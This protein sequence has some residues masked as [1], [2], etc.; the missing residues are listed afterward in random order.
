MNKE[1]YAKQVKEGTFRGFKPDPPEM[2]PMPVSD[3]HEV[4]VA[5]EGVAKV[6][7]TAKTDEEAIEEACDNVLARGKVTELEVTATDV[8]RMRENS[9][10]DKGQPKGV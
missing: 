8:T 7:V 5:F 1:E 9:S 4:W 10:V 6:Y 2:V 3:T